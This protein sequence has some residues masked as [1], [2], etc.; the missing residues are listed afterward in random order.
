MAHRTCTVLASDLDFETEVVSHKTRELPSS[1]QSYLIR[2]SQESYLEVLRPQLEKLCNLKQPG[3]MS[4]A[5]GRKKGGND[6]GGQI[7]GSSALVSAVRLNSAGTTH[8]W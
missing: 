4:K 5:F 8:R 7:F 3:K 2:A 1:M 6:Y